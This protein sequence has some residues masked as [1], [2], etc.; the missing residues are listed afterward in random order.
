[1]RAMCPVAGA[2]WGNS[3]LCVLQNEGRIIASLRCNLSSN[4]DC[5]MQSDGHLFQH[6]SPFSMYIIFYFKTLYIP[7]YFFHISTVNAMKRSSMFSYIITLQK[8][9]KLTRAVYHNLKTA[10]RVNKIALK[11]SIVNRHS[12]HL[13]LP[14]VDSH[15]NSN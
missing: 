2:S 8:R 4:T 15:R 12:W 10:F 9:I 13:I 3:S 1:M 7:L 11:Y 6:V 5:A 14:L